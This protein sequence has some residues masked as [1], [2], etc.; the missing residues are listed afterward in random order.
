MSCGNCSAK[1]E[2]SVTA[3]DPTALLEFDMDARTV[4]IDSADD[5]KDL[6]AAI[7][8]AGFEASAA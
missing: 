4:E 7:N 1:I 5:D 2:Q 3:A 8:N 6:L